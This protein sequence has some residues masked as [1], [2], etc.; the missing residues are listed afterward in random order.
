MYK[1]GFVGAGNM[2]FALAKAIAD[3]GL[4]ERF[5]VHDISQARLDLFLD[6]LPRVCVAQ[7]NAEVVRAAEVVF[8]AVKPQVIDTVLSEIQDTDT[9]VV[10]I[11]AGISLKHL[12]SRLKRARVFRVMPN[13]PC[14]VREMAAGFAAGSRAT[15]EDAETVRALLSASGTALEVQ[16]N[17]LD[18]VTGLSGSGPAFFARLFEAFIEAGTCN[19]ISEPI[20]RELT[21]KTALGTA[22]LLMEQLTA[23]QLVDM[24]SSPGGTTVAGRAVLEASDYREIIIRTVTAAT[25]RSQELG[26]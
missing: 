16:E 11:A 13:T 1:V 3:G 26:K 9:V 15:P 17:L 8:V 25:E 14:L 21:L 4:A 6:A 22:R 18:A 10:S 24:V 2:A 5:T 19:G 12:E 7:S 20:A 23:Q